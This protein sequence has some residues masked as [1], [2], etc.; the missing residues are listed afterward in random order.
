MNIHVTKLM[1]LPW[2]G[3]V[4]AASRVLAN[5]FEGWIILDLAVFDFNEINTG[6]AGTLVT[7]T[8]E[9]LQLV[10]NALC[11]DR[12]V[13]VR[14]VAHRTN[15]AQRLSLFLGRSPEKYT[16]NPSPYQNRNILPH[17]KLTPSENVVR[18]KEC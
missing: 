4:E 8:Y 18:A 14:Q 10:I 9:F 1:I 5:N 17:D 15:Y 6:M 16:L 11:F 2:C 12:H 13:T 7:P 3:A